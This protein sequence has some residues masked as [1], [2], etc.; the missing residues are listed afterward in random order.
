MTS[1]KRTCKA[2]IKYC[3]VSPKKMNLVTDLIRRNKA[4]D[5]VLKLTYATRLGAKLVLDLLNSAIANAV[6]NN[7]F[8]KSRL[9]IDEIYVGKAFTLKRFMAR[10]R[11]RSTRILKRFCNVTIILREAGAEEYGNFGKKKKRTK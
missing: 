6:N 11:G 5:A 4:E 10:G 8:D 3:T 2:S 1:D 9:V 7:N